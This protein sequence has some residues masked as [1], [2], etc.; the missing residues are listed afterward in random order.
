[1]VCTVKTMRDIQYPLR[2]MQPRHNDPD[3]SRVARDVSMQKLEYYTGQYKEKCGVYYDPHG[4]LPRRNLDGKKIHIGLYLDVMSDGTLDGTPLR[5]RQ[6]GARDISK[7]PGIDVAFSEPK[8]VSIVWAAAD[9]KIRDAIERAH[10]ESVREAIQYIEREC[11]WAR[12]GQGGKGER[13][14]GRIFG[15]QFQHGDSRPVEVDKGTPG[16]HQHRDGKYYAAD[17]QLHTHI[18]I[19]NTQLC[20]DGKWRALDV[21]TI[22]QAQK[23]AGAIQAAAMKRNLAKLGFVT[24]EV[25]GA[26]SNNFEIA[27]VP[28]GLIQIMS[29]RENAIL[30]A[31]GEGASTVTKHNALIKT[32]REKM[33]VE[34]RHGA[35]REEFASQGFTLD[36]GVMRSPNKDISIN[37]DAITRSLIDRVGDITSTESVV[38]RRTVDEWIANALRERSD[39]GATLDEIDHVRRELIACGA[40]LELGDGDYSTQQIYDDERTIADFTEAHYID[41]GSSIDPD[42]V[43]NMIES[44]EK[45]KQMRDEQ[46]QAVEILCSTA[47]RICVLE[48]PAGS[49]KSFALDP[50]RE[51]HERDGWT[52]I[53]TALKWDNVNELNRDAGFKDG[54]ALDPL[55][56][57]LKERQ[58]SDNAK[59]LFVIDEANMAS[60]GQIAPLMRARP[61]AK[62]IFVGDRAQE[63]GVG[64]GPAFDIAIQRGA[65]FAE[66][67]EGFRVKISEIQS[68]ANLI[69]AGRADAAMG[70]LERQKTFVW[71]D[72]SMRMHHEMVK[73]WMTARREFPQQ[74]TAIAVKSNAERREINRHV[75]QA[76]KDN[77]KL[78]S[79]DHEVKIAERGPRNRIVEAKLAVAVGEEIRFTRRSD[80]LGVVNGT[81]GRVVAIE[82][83][84]DIQVQLDPKYGGNTITVKKNSWRDGKRW[85]THA[86]CASIYSTEG[87]TVD[88]MIAGI[89]G[90]DRH[91]AYVALT[92]ARHH[93]KLHVDTG[94]L[95]HEA[96]RT[97]GQPVE[98]EALRQQIIAQMTRTRLKKSVILRQDSKSFQKKTPAIAQ[99]NRDQIREIATHIGHGLRINVLAG[100]MT[101]AAKQ[102]FDADKRNDPAAEKLEQKLLQLSDQIEIHLHKN[103]RA[104]QYL[105]HAVRKRLSQIRMFVDK[106][107]NVGRKFMEVLNEHAAVMRKPPAAPKPT[108]Q[109]NLAKKQEAPKPKPPV[110]KPEALEPRV[111]RSRGPKM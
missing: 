44:S 51:A 22:M 52:V 98:P 104:E 57:K 19:P 105:K 78:A 107:R 11:G 76:L 37:L 35:W 26:I 40:I 111:P 25:E 2:E 55:L 6:S 17:P 41:P 47:S 79:D 10:A 65:A 94:R 92:R 87:W 54:M 45:Y 70:Y 73:D 13:I 97:A 108:P 3:A 90:A 1:V 27:S 21:R 86:Y 83:S 109:I 48:A 77:G 33:I 66:M 80:A 110:K 38:E 102:L 23:V 59:I 71:H 9:I 91:D 89:N 34:D 50:I 5:Q 39:S 4:L 43:K 85:M 16:G 12:T 8:S 63:P 30:D 82:R 95:A 101:K 62:F 28:D 7:T 84:G 29:K 14:K 75:R 56:A 42:L 15:F 103:P 100:R 24:R 88:R 46:R 61:N 64:A 99:K 96:G 58:E 49:G 18:V 53:A 72:D 67:N 69:S 81:R 74:E 32:R 31:V 20:A 106:A 36:P 93:V 60:A 68:A